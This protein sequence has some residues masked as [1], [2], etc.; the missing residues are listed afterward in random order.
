[1][2][3]TV[4]ARAAAG[5][6]G[7]AQ[8]VRA[9]TGWRRYV[10]AALLGVAATAALP[11]VH[12]IPFVVVAFTGLVWLIEGS[13]GIAGA[14]A[15]GWWFGLGHFGTGFYWIANSLLVDAARF[16]WVYPF[17]VLFFGAAFA[18]Y[19][20][21]TT[22]LVRATRTRGTAAVL[23]LAVMWT[24]LE[25][26]RGHLFTGFP[27]N[28]IGT[29]WA[30]SDTMMQV[31]A[32]VG[33]Y[34]LGTVTVLAAAMPAT[35]AGG[36]Q[37]IVQRWGGT[38]AA[39]ALLG[40]IWAYGWVRLAGAGTDVVAGVLLRLVQPDI[41]QDLK[42]DPAQREQNFEATLAI[43]RSPGFAAATHVIWPETAI[44]F[45]IAEDAAR[46]E[47]LASAVPPRGFLISGAPRVERNTTG[48]LRRVWNSLYAFD[49]T[50]AITATY[51]KF[52]L[53]PFGEFVPFRWALD[54]L[55]LTPG[56]GDFDAG[57]GLRTLALAGFPAFSPLICY[58]VLFPGE[59]A[60]PERRPELLLNIT[61]DA[62]FG[63][64]PGP[65][66]HFAAARF[67]AVEEGLPL[68]RAANNGISAVVDSYG[69][70]VEQ[71]GLG[72]A[73]VVDSSLPRA[74]PPTIFSRAGDALLA[75]LLLVLSLVALLVRRRG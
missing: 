30:A 4:L 66:Q 49:R 22:A 65:F 35:L 60:A 17:C 27:W 8:G 21:L 68:V 39:V 37:R 47:R 18:F 23:I 2:I 71:L 48:G 46:R 10:L 6:N 43:T 58:E 55:R 11:P 24:I 73:G 53:V 36:S 62:W 70:V 32:V 63:M 29:I 45:P 15:I 13:R 9:V 61:N 41:P 34:G 54:W 40:G 42:W 26:L 5:V 67:R 20:A 16:G 14:F 51:D 31:A 50:G 25:W 72:R 28:L 38:L 1:M 74:L 56:M 59:V 19:T 57:P 75:A 52:H 7:I 44:P 3:A 69:R 12:L 64:S 33:L